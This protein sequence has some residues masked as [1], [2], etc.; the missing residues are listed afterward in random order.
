MIRNAPDRGP[1]RHSSRHDLMRVLKSLERVRKRG[2]RPTAHRGPN[3]SLSPMSGRGQGEGQSNANGLTASSD[4][5]A[6]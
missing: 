2:A 5:G 6:R 3:Y 4:G 1:R